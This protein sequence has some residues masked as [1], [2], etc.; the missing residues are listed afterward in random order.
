MGKVY[1]ISQPPYFHLCHF[2]ALLLQDAPGDQGDQGLPL[3]SQEEGREE[4]QDQEEC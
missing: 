2:R 1:E 3:E 4:C